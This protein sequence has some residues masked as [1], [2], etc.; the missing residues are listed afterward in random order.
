[1]K[2]K[3]YQV[4][5]IK[6]DLSCKILKTLHER[7]E[8]INFILDYSLDKLNVDDINIKGVLNNNGNLD[9]YE[10]HRICKKTILAQLICAEFFED[11]ECNNYLHKDI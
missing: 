5:M 3:K 9:I 10:C 1:M 2:V 11:C 7:A 8:A 4:I 6:K